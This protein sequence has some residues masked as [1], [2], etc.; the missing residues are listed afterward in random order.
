MFQTGGSG[1]GFFL[2][3]LPG[4]GGPLGYSLVGH[5]RQGTDHI[6]HVLLGNDVE[7]PAGPD[8]AVEDRT[9]LPCL[10]APEEQP[11]LFLMRRSA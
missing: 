1:R 9:G 4:R 3:G 10:R 5:R 11:V 7:Q 2:A 8:Q 6:E